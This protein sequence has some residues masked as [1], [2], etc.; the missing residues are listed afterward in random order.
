VV[1]GYIG[2]TAR[3]LAV[4]RGEVDVIIQNLDSVRRFV[5]TGE[6][7]PLLQISGPTAAR[8]TLQLSNRVPSLGGTD[9][10]V[11]QGF[12]V[13]GTAA[14]DA[15]KAAAALSVIISAGRLIVAPA[16]L[17]EPTRI[18][19]QSTVLGVLQSVELHNA[20]DRAGLTIQAADATKAREDLQA[21]KRHMSDFAVL[22][23][24]AIEQAR[25]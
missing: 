8:Q 22:V 10:L 20:A 21:S 1:T 13:H 16:G 17:A 24:S 7:V 3:A 19:L 6:L 2:S 14:M 18:C 23:R 15:E 12:A 5:D 11:Q 4:M 25:Q 9:G